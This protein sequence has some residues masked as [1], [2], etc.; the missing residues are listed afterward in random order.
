METGAGATSPLDDVDVSIHPTCFGTFLHVDEDGIPTSLGRGPLGIA[1][2]DD[3]NHLF[4]NPLQLCK[5]ILYW[6]G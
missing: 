6:V 2:W 3:V 5:Y 1:F 4:K